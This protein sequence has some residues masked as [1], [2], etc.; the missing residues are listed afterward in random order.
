V[1]HSRVNVY[2]AFTEA[3]EEYY[4][5]AHYDLVQMCEAQQKKCEKKE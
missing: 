4:C 2:F 3:E 5:L 1:A